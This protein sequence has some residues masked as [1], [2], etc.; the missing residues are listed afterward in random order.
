MGFITE[1]LQELPL[2]AVLK[3]RLEGLEKDYST[4]QTERDIVKSENV[5]MQ[6]DNQALRRQLQQCH[7]E[8]QRLDQELKKR[9]SHGLTLD[10]HSEVIL[11]LLCSRDTAEVKQIAET[12]GIH[13]VEAE[14]ALDK[15][16]KTQHVDAHYNM[17]YPTKYSLA[18]KG[19][20]YVV[21]H[22][23]FK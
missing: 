5:R 22:K 23:L 4:L 9:D 1:M 18:E 19:R 7:A 13:P 21:T 2:S 14:H 3:A 16:L 11:S 12:L 6:T 20:D 10:G 15:L 8:N 17:I